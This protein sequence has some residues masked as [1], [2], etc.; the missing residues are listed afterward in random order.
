MLIGV[1]WLASTTRGSP[2]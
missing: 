1:L 2:I